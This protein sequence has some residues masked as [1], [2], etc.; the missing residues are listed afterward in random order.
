MWPGLA[1]FAGAGRAASGFV[2]VKD[3]RVDSAARARHGW[4]GL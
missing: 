2:Y 3:H 4:R 1:A